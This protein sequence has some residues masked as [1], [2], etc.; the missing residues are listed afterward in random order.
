M[1]QNLLSSKRRKEGYG[2]SN[3]PAVLGMG[4][5][6]LVGYMVRRFW[7]QIKSMWA[8]K[9]IA[10]AVPVV[11]ATAPLSMVPPTGPVF[12]PSQMALPSAL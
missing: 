6:I 11:A 1:I 10:P 4:I 12:Q 3:V 5:V 2:N 7:P 9:Q 8:A